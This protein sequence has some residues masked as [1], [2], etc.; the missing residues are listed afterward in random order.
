MFMFDILYKITTFDEIIN[1]KHHF[2]ILKSQ[3]Q[4]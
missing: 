2:L 3:K 1:N 4:L